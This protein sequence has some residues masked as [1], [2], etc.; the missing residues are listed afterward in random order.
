MEGPAWRPDRYKHKVPIIQCTH[1]TLIIIR[2]VFILT[3]S[4]F[5]A[6]QGCI[7]VG[8]YF[9]GDFLVF[10]GNRDDIA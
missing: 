1:Y 2:E 4:I 5:I 8:M 9:C 10:T 6:L 7:S 3:L